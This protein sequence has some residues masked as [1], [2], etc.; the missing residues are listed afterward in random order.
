VSTFR[1]ILLVVM[2]LAVTGCQS[3][4]GTP[5]QT[6]MSSGEDTSSPG[7]A[8]APVSGGNSLG[9]WTVEP[10]YATQDK[11]A[12]GCGTW[13]IPEGFGRRALV[14]RIRNKTT[15][16]LTRWEA[17]TATASSDAGFVYGCGGGQGSGYLESAPEV[18]VIP[19]GFGIPMSLAVDVPTSATGLVITL[20]IE[21]NDFGCPGNTAC[22]LAIPISAFASTTVEAQTDIPTS[23][24]KKLGDTITQGPLSVTPS[25]VRLAAPCANSDLNDA[26]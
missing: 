26:H 15:S 14:F 17:I 10:L 1:K 8:V 12:S 6:F 25:S 2:V 16:L 5:A 11:T 3:S 4:N 18:A 20:K 24:P 21:A 9:L 7:T 23:G 22:T 13:P 19:P